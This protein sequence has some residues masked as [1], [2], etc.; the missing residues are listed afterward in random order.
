MILLTTAERWIDTIGQYW[1]CLTQNK[2]GEQKIYSLQVKGYEENGV[3]DFSKY[4]GVKLMEHSWIGN[5]FMDS[6]SAL[7]YKHPLQIAW[8]GDYADDFKWPEGQSEFKPS[9][10]YLWDIA[11]KDN[12]EEIDIEGSEFDYNGKYLVNHTLQDCISFDEYIENSIEDKWAIH[13]LSLLTA[14]GNDLGGGD[15]HEGYMGYENVGDWCWDEISIEDEIPE[16]YNPVEFVFKEVR[17]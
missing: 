14:C 10:N 1:K 13:P 8:V 11:W 4:N 17:C 12:R 16:G 5:S 6:L 3:I 7:I 2:E 15:F 9:P